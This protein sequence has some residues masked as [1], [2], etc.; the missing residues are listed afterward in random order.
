[1]CHDALTYVL[2]SSAVNQEGVELVHLVYAV[3]SEKSGNGAKRAKHGM[4]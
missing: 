4:G 2:K 3:E 1:M